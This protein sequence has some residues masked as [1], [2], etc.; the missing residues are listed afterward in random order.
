MP[1][2]FTGQTFGSYKLVSQLG[3]GG[4]ASVYRGYQESIDRSVA[5]KILP[6][7]FLHDPNFSQR[8]LAEARI[9]AKL[10]HPSILP[11]YDFGTANDVPYIVMPL[12][13]KG[14]LGDR[15][16]APLSVAEVVRIVTPIAAAL[17]YAHKHG[18]LHRDVKPS[19]ILFDQNDTPFLGD[20]GI[21][22]ALEASSS[23][24]GT[25]IVGTPD[26]MSPEQARG[27]TLDGR[28]DVY[29]LG[30]VAYQAL[31][32]SNL[33]KATTPI[34]VML[35]HATEPPPPL[36]E[37]RPD[38][39]QAVD[40]VVQKALAKYP[41]ERYQ[42]GAE[43]AQ[44]LAKAAF[45]HADA[46]TW[47]EPKPSDNVATM[48]DAKAPP[49]G[50]PA[51]GPRTP[52]PPGT[53][54]GT[55]QQ[56]TGS[57]SAPPAKKGGIGGMLVGIGGGMIAG[58]VV[59]VVALC[60]GI[61]LCGMWAASLETS[62]PTP[63]PLPTST[64]KPIPTATPEPTALPFVFFDDFSD[65]GSGWST[66][67]SES[68]SAEY[69]SGD[70]VITLAQTDW[71]VWTY[72]N[73]AQFSNI[74]VD[75]AVN[76][77]R[78]GQDTSFGIMCNYVDSDNYYYLAIDSGGFYAIIQYAGADTFLTGGG[79]WAQSDLITPNAGSY[80]LG[81]ACANDFM[82]LYV[83]GQ[84]ID[85]VSVSGPTTSDVGVF[86]WTNE[87]SDEEIHFDDFAVSALP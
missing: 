62:T 49:V 35:K 33:F 48:V 69:G 47:P 9:L 68:G 11:L 13:A 31:T 30:V 41:V 71:F 52:L 18:V 76:V 24:T 61:I 23:M 44:A 12:M 70:M 26:Y 65:S 54:A 17:D 84:L 37:S 21:S 73:R 85:S 80:F 7:E 60:G 10:T 87:S 55:P 6:P 28:S 40:D 67:S 2:D 3:R 22:K 77:V 15:L 32:G 75:V 86:A 45:P 66:F 14:T 74:F 79:E 25:G 29:S 53:Q 50:K 78:A 38:I 20:F 59:A 5:V 64:P 1:T 83:D 39:P 82:A 36:R 46:P 51:T 8:F 63:R 16:H 43:F 72:S 34:G 27:E 42:T 4:M 57:V 81:A 58:I 56:A 19:N